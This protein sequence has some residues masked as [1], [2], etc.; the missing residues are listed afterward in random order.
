M[1][2]A[3]ISRMIAMLQEVDSEDGDLIGLHDDTDNC[4][5]T[6]RN[7][8]T[9]CHAIFVGLRNPFEETEGGLVNIDNKH[10]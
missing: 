2:E 9:K 8:T 1:T 3:E 4:V 5:K 10:C 6:F 7:V